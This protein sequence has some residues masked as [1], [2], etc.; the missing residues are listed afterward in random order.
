VGTGRGPAA[1]AAVKR[2]V[3]AMR[4]MSAVSATTAA[5][6]AAVIASCDEIL[7]E[8]RHGNSLSS[9]RDKRTVQFIR[10]TPAV[11]QHHISELSSTY[12]SSMFVRF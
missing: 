2:V 5:V 3:G 10:W 8:L 9:H 4:A 1:I 7:R 11:M 12:V 6:A